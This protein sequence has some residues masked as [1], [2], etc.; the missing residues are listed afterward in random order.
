MDQIGCGPSARRS[1]RRG[2]QR[3]APRARLVLVAER[4][5]AGQRAGASLIAEG[6]AESDQCPISKRDRRTKVAQKSP[7]SHL[8]VGASSCRT[9]GCELEA[10][11]ELAD[12]VQQF[13]YQHSA[14]VVEPEVT[15]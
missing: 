9:L 12:S 14:G 3:Q 4:S 13:A 15:A 11:L 10:S 5:C 2:E 6:L 8:E 1:S 7:G